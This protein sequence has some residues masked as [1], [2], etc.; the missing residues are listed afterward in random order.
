MDQRRIANGAQEIR[1]L[2]EIEVV[3]DGRNV[4]NVAAFRNG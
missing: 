3:D 1:A 2:D 4:E